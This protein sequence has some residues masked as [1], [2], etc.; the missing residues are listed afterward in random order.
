MHVRNR[1][2]IK[3]VRDHLGLKN[4]I[5]TY[6]HP[7]KDGYNR[8]PYVLLIV[9]DFG[10]LKNIIIPFFYKKLAGDKGIQFYE[11]LDKIGIDPMVP[12]SYKLLYKLHESGFYSENPKFE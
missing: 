5:Y 7:G 12:E 2:L 8:A 4:K 9:R 11:W 6:H 3:G 1:D 10:S